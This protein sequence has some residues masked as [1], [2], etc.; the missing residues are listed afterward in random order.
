MAF[1]HQ[2]LLK[3]SDIVLLR[4]KIDGTLRGMST[5]GINHMED[6]TVIKIGPTFFTNY[7]KGGPYTY[8]ITGYF[9]LK[10]N[11]CSYNRIPV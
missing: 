5:I 10:G 6:R 8:L 7:Y 3:Y 1:L 9:V 4:D 2:A 11:I